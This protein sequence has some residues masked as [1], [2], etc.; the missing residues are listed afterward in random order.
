MIFCSFTRLI[1]YLLWLKCVLS[2]ISG[3]DL[4]ELRD[5][6]GIIKVT[7][8]NYPLLSKSARNFYSIL[9]ITKSQVS[10]K[11]FSCDIC[12]KFEPTWT[13]VSRTFLE[14]LPSDLSNRVFFFIADITENPQLVYELNLT[15]VPHCLI[16]LP[17]END[18]SFQWSSY[19]FY[20]FEITDE[21]SNDPIIFGNFMAKLLNVYIEIDQDFI[22]NDFIRNFFIFV[23]IFIIL[24]K[25]VLTKIKRKGLFF[26][27]LFSLFILMI[28]I[29]GYKFTS[30]N[31]IPFIAY[32]DKHEIM[33]F[34]GTFNWQFGIEIL[35]VSSM[36][37]F[38]SIGITT[39][40]LLPKYKSMSSL[41]V[42]LILICINISI[43]QMYSYFISCFTIKYPEYPF[44]IN[45]LKMYEYLYL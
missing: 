1:W 3:E 8:Q 22:V 45:I 23:F 39:L 15:N 42:C 31:N 10:F 4:V 34:A 13:K 35:T 28:S 41:I 27:C 44:K 38:M 16:Y 6:N 24:K 12:K 33:F 20:N 29:T 25:K 11:E 37:L 43:F 9:Y 26:S 18:E 19:P 5:K 2:E 21:N 40:I 7:E 30:M 32:N 14:Q 17:E 36:Y